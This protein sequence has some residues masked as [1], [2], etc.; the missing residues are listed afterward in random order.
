MTGAGERNMCHAKITESWGCG[1]VKTSER[2]LSGDSYR[3]SGAEY[4]AVATIA[5]EIILRHHGA[6]RDGNSVCSGTGPFQDSS[7]FLPFASFAYQAL[8]A[9]PLVFPA[10]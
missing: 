8:A 3:F 1:G 7:A 6:L 9:A 4:G 10:G 5:I 2:S